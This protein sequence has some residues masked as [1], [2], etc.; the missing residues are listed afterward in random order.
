MPKNL[1]RH[2]KAV[3]VFPNIKELNNLI[4]ILIYRFLRE[5]HWLQIT[6]V[7]DTGLIATFSSL[8]PFYLHFF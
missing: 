6:G 5:E 2:C 3:I 4:L 7:I 1:P 8:L